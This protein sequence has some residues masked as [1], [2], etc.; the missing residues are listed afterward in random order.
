MMTAARF[1][2]SASSQMMNLVLHDATCVSDMIPSHD[3]MVK[4]HGGHMSARTNARVA[5]EI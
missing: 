4:L 3:D 5:V 2:R 1:G